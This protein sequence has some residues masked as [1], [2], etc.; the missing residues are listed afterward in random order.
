MTD[1][2]PKRL[3]LAEKRALAR[4]LFLD[5][6]FRDTN[7]EVIVAADDLQPRPEEIAAWTDAIANDHIS[8]K[9]ISL[10]V[11]LDVLDFFKSQG[12]GYQTRINAV[13]KAYMLVKKSTTRG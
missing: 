13:L 12:P 1:E 7:D 4:P 2:P 8:R 6:G 5:A 11:E 10:R 3:S 9:L